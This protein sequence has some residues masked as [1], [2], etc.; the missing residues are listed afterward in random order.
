MRFPPSSQPLVGLPRSS[1]I[2]RSVHSASLLSAID[3]PPGIQRR[4][5]E[6]RTTR[7]MAEE[8]ER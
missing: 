6:G 5:G 2:T 1:P 8:A 4:Q 3:S 7:P